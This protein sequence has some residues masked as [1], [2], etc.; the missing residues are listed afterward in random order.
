MTAWGTCVAYPGLFQVDDKNAD[1]IYKDNSKFLKYLRNSGKLVEDQ[2]KGKNYLE[3]SKYI[4]KDMTEFYEQI[5]T[6]MEFIR[7]LKKN[8]KGIWV[9]SDRVIKNLMLNIIIAL[10]FAFYIPPKTLYPCFAKEYDLQRILLITRE[11]YFEIIKIIKKYED[12]GLKSSE[13]TRG[14]NM[15]YDLQNILLK[16]DLMLTNKYTMATKK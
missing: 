6:D 11:S 15:Y 1:F 12:E 7:L 13:I 4:L 16:K 14:R 9:R 3:K 2:I 8:L 5:S 10:N